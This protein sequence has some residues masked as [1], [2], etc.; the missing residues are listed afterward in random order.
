ML[1]S[2]HKKVQ[3]QKIGDK[4]R[5]TLYKLMNNT[6]YGIEKMRNRTDAVSNKQRLFKLDIKTKLYVTKTFGNNLVAI[7]K[8][9]VTLTLKNPAYVG[10]CILELSKV[11]MYEFYYDYIKNKYGNNSKTL[12]IHRNR[13][14]N[15]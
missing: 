10:M 11:L 15:V 12:T 9:N 6:V 4:A 1:N 14:F 5:K 8:N 3:K 2:I 7:R 13:Q